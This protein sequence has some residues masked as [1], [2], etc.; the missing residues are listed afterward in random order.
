VNSA[1]GAPRR[2]RGLLAA[3]LLSLIGIAVLIGLGVWQLERK[4]WKEQL[5]ARLTER[6]AAAPRPMPPRESWE[7]L[8]QD[9]LEFRRVAFPAEFLHEHEALVHSSGSAFRPDASGPGYWVFTPARLA[10]GS[11]VIVNRGFVPEG[12]QDANARGEGQVKGSVEIVA[13]MRWP[14]PR[15]QFTPA[16]NPGRNIWYVRDHR[17]IAEAKGLGTVAP[18]Y[19]EQEAPPAPGGLPRAGRLSV[20]LANNHLQY[21]LT[22]FGLAGGLLAVFSIWAFQGLRT[23]RP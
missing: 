9:D 1:A 12:R 11:L 13:A 21:A 23:P 3:G 7:R 6:I 20:S 16:D 19:L 4:A 8:G 17:A 5:I 2:W 15:G 18:F 10:G 14:E 22:W